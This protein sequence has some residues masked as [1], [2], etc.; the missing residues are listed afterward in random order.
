MDIGKEAEQPVEYPEPLAPGQ[1][2]VREPSPQVEPVK[3]PAHAALA[4]GDNAIAAYL[5]D[6]PVEDINRVTGK[7]SNG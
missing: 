5:L 2:P 7:S 4:G 6:V 1:K 3:E